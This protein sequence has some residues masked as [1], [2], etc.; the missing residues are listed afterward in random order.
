[1]NRTA[2]KPRDTMRSYLDG[3]LVLIQ[4]KQDFLGHFFRY[5]AI[6]KEIKGDAI[7]HSLVFSNN[8]LELGLCHFPSRLITDDQVIFTQILVLR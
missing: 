1:M 2:A 7:D 6:V 4:F 5:G 3:T 8:G